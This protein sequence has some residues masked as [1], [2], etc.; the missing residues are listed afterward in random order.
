MYNA[1]AYIAVEAKKLAAIIQFR[2]VCTDK[3]SRF[4][5][6]TDSTQIRRRCR[7]TPGRS[8]KEPF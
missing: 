4:S 6:I 2:R 1:K 7:V 3:M 5:V 8:G